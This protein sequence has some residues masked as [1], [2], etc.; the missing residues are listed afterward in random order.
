MELRVARGSGPTGRI[1]EGLM[2]DR[3]LLRRDGAIVSYGVPVRGER[4]LN[5][6]AGRLDKYE[7]GLRLAERGVSVV[8]H[9]NE[10]G[11]LRALANG[12]E[13][14]ARKRNHVGGRDIRRVNSGN[15]VRS[16][17][18]RGW[19]FFTPYIPSR[20]EYRVYVYRGRHLGTYE[21]VLRYPE[22][23]RRSIG[24]NYHNGYAFQLVGSANVPR[25]AVDLAN[26]AVAGL[27]LDFGAVDILAGSDGRYYVLEV[28]TAPGVESGER[29]VAQGLVEHWARWAE[30]GYPVRN[31]TPEA[32]ARRA[33]RVSARTGRQ[34]RSARLAPQ[35]AFVERRRAERRSTDRRRG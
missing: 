10:Q 24:R 35:P 23:R 9:L 18:I 33:A 17:L 1:L 32:E 13:L 31:G 7:Q 27:D 25:A 14:L 28:N 5:G 11:A 6:N 8:P 34:P 20:T 29:Q 22:R 3:G 12:R 26:A 21:K 15:Q 16:R 19:H 4:V 30:R 2:R